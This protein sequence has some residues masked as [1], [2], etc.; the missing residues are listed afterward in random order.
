MLCVF[1]KSFDI[2]EEK[3]WKADRKIVVWDG[4]SDVMWWKWCKAITIWINTNK[5]K[6]TQIL[7]YQ[8]EKIK[9][10]YNLIPQIWQNL[11][12]NL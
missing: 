12:K 11:P 1:Q 4:W 8:V 3:Y 9:D 10:I 2:L 5:P 7:D 6:D